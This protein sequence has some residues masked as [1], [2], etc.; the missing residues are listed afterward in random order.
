M[1]FD[2]PDRVNN[3]VKLYADDSK[4][5][6]VIKNWEDATNVQKDLS[7]ICEWSNDWLM[8]LNVSKCKVMHYGRSNPNYDYYMRDSDNLTK[9]L[10]KTNRE[11]DLGVTFTPDLSWKYHILEITARANRI[12]GSLK[13]AFVS[14]DST[15]WKNLYISL[16]RPHLEYAV[17]VWSP[18]KEMDIGLIEKVQ[19]RATKI[20]YSMR[21]LRYEARLTKWGINRLEDRR[22]RGD[23][24][25]MY[26]SVNGLDEINWE[27]NPVMITPTDRVLT[28]SNGV[29]IRRDTFKSKIRNDF[30]KQVSTRHNY[31]FNRITPIWNAL[32]E[33]IVQAPTLNMFKKGLDDRFKSNGRY[34]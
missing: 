23:L 24:I 7:S 32:P 16:V 19:A 15:L 30:A 26:K 17:Q 28:R 6:A 27:R 14:R 12:L 8:Q 34:S 18:T 22:V 4:I 2:L 10:E 21:D 33:K 9:R 11:K 31:F 5:L 25:E 20:P 29:K 3:R 13:K 1:L